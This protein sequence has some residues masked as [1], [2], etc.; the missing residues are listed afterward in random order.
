MVIGLPFTSPIL[1]ATRLN[2]PSIYYAPLDVGEW[3]LPPERDG[4]LVVRGKKD[5]FDFLNKNIH[6]AGDI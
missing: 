3:N 6:K 2:R 1:A 4:I 5:L